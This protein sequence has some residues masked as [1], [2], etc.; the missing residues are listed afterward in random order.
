[1]RE[2]GRDGGNGDRGNEGMTE[3]RREEGMERR[4]GWRE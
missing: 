4:K 3:G 2:G 1:M